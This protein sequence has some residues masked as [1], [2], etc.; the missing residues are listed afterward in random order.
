MRQIIHHL[1]K[2]PEQVKR[3]ILHVSIMVCAVVLGALW[4]YSL[5]TNLNSTETQ[6]KIDRDLK[7]LSALKANLIGG[8]D[9]I[10]DTDLNKK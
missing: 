1:R 2:Q 4:I 7:P 10:T 3:H 9:S 6:A 8:Y 5:G